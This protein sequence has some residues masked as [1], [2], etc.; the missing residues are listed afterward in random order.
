MTIDLHGLQR[1]GF[2]ITQSGI[3]SGQVIELLAQT[4]A[5]LQDCPAAGIRGLAGRLPAIRALSDSVDLRRQV[6]PVLGPE[7]RLVRSILF[8]KTPQTNWK[9]TWHQDLSIAVREPADTPGYGPWSE[10]AGIPHVQPPVSVLKQMLTLRIHLDPAD[11][12]NGALRVSPGTHQLG[13]I[14]AADA[15]GVAR[16]Y[17]ERLCRVRP[18]D[19]LLFRPLLLHASSKAVPGHNSSPHRRIIHLEYAASALPDSLEWNENA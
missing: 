18:G 8:D 12:H 7:A 5:L 9:V 14:P 13:R 15:A 2:A 4:A 3:D 1:D 11:E 10:K 6:E 17:G 19:L 16:Q